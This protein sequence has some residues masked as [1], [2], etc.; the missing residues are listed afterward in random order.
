MGTCRK[1]KGEIE[2]EDRETDR[3]T[4]RETDRQTDRQR[5]SFILLFS[6][7][8]MMVLGCALIFQLIFTSLS[9]TQA[10]TYNDDTITKHYSK[11]I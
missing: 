6:I 11:K 9:Y 3:Q 1:G 10:C 5:E 4:D 8:R 7:L 2:G